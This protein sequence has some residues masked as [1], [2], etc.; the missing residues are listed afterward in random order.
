MNIEAIE[1]VVYEAWLMTRSKRTPRAAR[2]S[3]V[4]EMLAV[5]LFLLPHDAHASAKGNALI[6]SVL[7]P[8]VAELS[9][10]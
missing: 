4:G 3:I 10:K 9:G 8:A 5:P 1:T 7:A 2:E 6:A